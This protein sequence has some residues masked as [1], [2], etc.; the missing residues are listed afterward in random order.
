[1]PSHAFVL[2]HL[3]FL[4]CWQTLCWH[5]QEKHTMIAAPGCRWRQLILQKVQILVAAFEVY[6]ECNNLRCTST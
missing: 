6:V 2:G 3:S 4:L 5:Q 1:M